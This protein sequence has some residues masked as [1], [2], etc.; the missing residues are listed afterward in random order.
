MF[1]SIFFLPVYILLGGASFEE[2]LLWIFGVPYLGV[3][4]LLCLGDL[5]MQSVLHF[6]LALIFIWLCAK[7]R[8][9][10]PWH[11]LFLQMR[12]Y[13]TFLIHIYF[14]TKNIIE[15]YQ[16]SGGNSNLQVSGVPSI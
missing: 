7:T 2:Q 11:N 14:F 10:C 15:T 12:P 8:S 1:I 3:I 5:N 9:L 16:N 13:S 4:I 6:L